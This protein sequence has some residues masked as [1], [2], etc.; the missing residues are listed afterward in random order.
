MTFGEYLKQK[1]LDKEITLRGFAKLVDISPVYLCDLEKGRKAAPSMEV[2]QKM[3]SKLAL[4]KE[5]S[6]RFY[7][8]AALEQTAKNPIPKDLNAFLKDN[9]VIVSALR[10]AKDLDATDEEWQ[11]FIDKLR[12]SREGK[13]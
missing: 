7:D 5:E 4:N 11:D 3:V 10:T 6:E 9:R 8:L 1:R 12:K 2:M 13:P